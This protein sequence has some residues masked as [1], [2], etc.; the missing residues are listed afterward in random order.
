VV[1]VI[2]GVDILVVF[3]GVP[4]IFLLVDLKNEPI[5]KMKKKV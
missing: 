2:C 1:V 5:E 4:F 3:G